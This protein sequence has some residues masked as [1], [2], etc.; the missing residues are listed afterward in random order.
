MQRLGSEFAMWLSKLDLKLR[1]PFDS[2]L[3]RQESAYP[4]LAS[5]PCFKYDY[6]HLDPPLASIH[7]KLSCFPFF[8]VSGSC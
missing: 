8:R 1:F 5:L 2:D 4:S 6:N 7:G 3:Q